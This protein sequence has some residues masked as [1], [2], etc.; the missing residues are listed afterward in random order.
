M[1]IVSWLSAH[2]LS[3]VQSL[4]IIASLWFTR[5]ALR[6]D[7]RARDIGHLISLA[8]QHR[9]L[10][11]EL[12]RRPELQRVFSKKVDLIAHPVSPAEEEFLNLAL[13]HFQNGWSLTGNISGWTKEGLVKDLQSFFGYPLPRS[14]WEQ[15]KAHRDPVFVEFVEMALAENST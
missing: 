15:T 14:V 11:S 5:S 13:V 4:G 6:Q 8:Q 9:E 1:E 10:W 3:L 2:W 7:A 12:H